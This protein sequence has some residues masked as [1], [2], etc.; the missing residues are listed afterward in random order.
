MATTEKLIKILI[1]AY[2]DASFSS[3]AKLQTNPIVLPVNPKSF[4]QNYKLTTS[5][6]KPIT[7]VVADPEIL[8]LD[9]I[10]DGTNT[11]AGY[12]YNSKNHDVKEQLS[13]F[14]NTVYEKKDT[15]K[16]T[17]FLKIKWGDT[18]EFHGILE[19]LDLHYTLFKP[20]ADPLRIEISAT[21]SNIISKIKNAE[22]IT[23]EW[24]WDDLVLNNATNEAI[25]NVLDW[26]TYSATLFNTWGISKKVN[27]SYLVLFHGPPGT[28]KT[29]T[30]TLIGQKTNKNVHRVVLAS[31][32]SKYIGETEK[33]LLT[34]LQ[35][36]QKSNSI[37]FFDE[38]DALFGK[39]TEISDAHDSYA[40][41]E[42]SYLLSILESFNGIVIFSVQKDT[43]QPHISRKFQEKVP[44]FL[45]NAT[46]RYKLW[47]NAIPKKIKLNPEV[48]L[49]LL[50]EKYELSG[51]EIS[52]ALQFAVLK[53]I[54]AK[55]KTISQAL[56]V[57]AILREYEKRE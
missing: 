35:F 39:R 25:E 49:E 11:I 18:L 16:H 5:N 17:R 10:L 57:K 55:E 46:E 32:I 31:L 30:A 44:F 43:L 27:P 1:Y 24:H 40:N 29:L 47:Q 48:N 2:T 33:K 37:L 4:S 36:A 22:V 51:A 38:A 14:M 3:L 23:T 6:I 34:L 52:N 41:L 21:F 9:F 45:P 19:N 54:K 28:G 12:K 26:L 56:I 8:K 53:M 15:E 42:V 50:S 7:K 13:I 20:N